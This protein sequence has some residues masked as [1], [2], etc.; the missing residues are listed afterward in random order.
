MQ[1]R[2]VVMVLLQ[3]FIIATQQEIVLYSWHINFKIRKTKKD[4][5]EAQTCSLIKN[6][7]TY[8]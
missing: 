6:G 4:F 7:H 8:N 5:A 3:I 1:H 2:I